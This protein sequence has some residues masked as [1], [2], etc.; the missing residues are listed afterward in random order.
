M[1]LGLLHE[2]FVTVNFSGVGSLAPRPTP[3]MEDQ[4]L[5]FVWTLHFNL[6]GGGALPSA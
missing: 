4:G 6:S 1:G 2:V 5:Y 3:N